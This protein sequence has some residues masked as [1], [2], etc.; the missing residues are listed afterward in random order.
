MAAFSTANAK[1][2]AFV[3]PS[4]TVPANDDVV[5][6][7]TSNSLTRISGSVITPLSLGDG[8]VMPS[9]PAVQGGV[10]V[11]SPFLYTTA[12][13]ATSTESSALRS[14]AFIVD[15]S[16]KPVD[17]A[18]NGTYTAIVASSGVGPDNAYNISGLTSLRCDT[19]ATSTCTVASAQNAFFNGVTCDYGCVVTSARGLVARAVLY[20][21]NATIGTAV[22]IDI[23]DCLNCTPT[24]QTNLR[25]AAATR[26]TTN[27][28]V[29][30]NSNSTGTGA[31]IC[32]GTT[33][34]T[35]FWRGAANQLLTQGDWNTRHYLSSS[36]PTVAAGAGAGTGPTIAISG[37]DHGFTLTLTTGSAPSTSSTIATIT[38]GS[39]WTLG[40][41]ASFSPGNAATAA[42]AVAAH[43]FIST[44][45]TAS[46][47]FTSN[48]TALGATTQYIWRFTVMR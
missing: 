8:T 17:N 12:V 35:S 7:N 15:I 48:G 22:G 34:D 24:T 42:L 27:R 28:A 29:H 30:I 1:Q 31:G 37:S 6:T 10:L 32:F 18:A 19:F 45:S 14:T 4:P 33:G 47:V 9:R 39:S 43:P 46:L 25:I 38:W 40:P 23:A 11:P 21:Q 16:G 5:Y 36:T 41:S 20:G 2:F 13:A 26:A 44:I 3:Y